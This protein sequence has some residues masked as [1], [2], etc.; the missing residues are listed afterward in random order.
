MS[1]ATS[2]AMVIATA[3]LAERE[4]CSVLIASAVLTEREACAALCEDASNDPSQSFNWG[5]DLL[6]ARIRARGDK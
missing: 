4:A 2:A 5:Y 6:A 1:D 3:R